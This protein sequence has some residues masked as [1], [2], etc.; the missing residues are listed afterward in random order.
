MKII[1]VKIVQNPLFLRQLYQMRIAIINVQKIYA[2][3][4]NNKKFI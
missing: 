1:A 4:G 2:I 3:D